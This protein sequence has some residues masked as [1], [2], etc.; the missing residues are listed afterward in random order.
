[1]NKY[2]YSIF[3]LVVALFS[4]CSSDY[5]SALPTGSSALVSINCTDAEVSQRLMTL[6]NFLHVEDIEDC[7]IDFTEKIYLFETA[8]GNLGL[9][10]KIADEQKVRT[11]FKTLEKDGNAVEGPERQKCNFYTLYGKCI[12][13]YNNNSLLIVGPIIASAQSEMI[14]V[15]AC[16]L[17]QDEEDSM[18]GTPMMDKLESLSGALCIVAQADAFPQKLT[19]LF[20]VGM[21][22]D[23]ELSD[24]VL[25]ASVNIKDEVLYINGEPMS[26]NKQIDNQLKSTYS[27]F[28]PITSKYVDVLGKRSVAGLFANVDGK[29]FLPV[30]QKS[31]ALWALLAGANQAIDMNAII[32]SIDGDMCLSMPSYA[33]KLNLALAAQLNNSAFMSDVDYW[34]KSAQPGSSITSW[35]KDAYCY[36]SEDI[37]FY[38]GV[39]PG[40]KPELYSGSTAEGARHSILKADE[41]LSKNIRDAVVGQNLACVISISALLPD[42]AGIVMMMLP[43]TLK[44]SNVV[45]T[46]GKK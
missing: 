41:P 32:S 8:D 26:F 18:L 6:T 9:C 38:F 11:I 37:K 22:K 10:A 16:Y 27:I 31:E 21:P 14:Q 1:M 4:S 44:I 3:F 33:E 39:T 45:Y 40:P 20:T 30:I 42:D 28:R 23:T 5:R 36:S 17:N 7:G 13:A 24:C 35:E 29:K 15:L 43:R 25:C 2:L 46:V 12:A 19:P 34:K